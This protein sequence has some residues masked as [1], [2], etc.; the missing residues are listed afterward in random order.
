MLTEVA[1]T[2]GIPFL[3][4]P[5]T[6]LTCIVSDLTGNPALGIIGGANPIG[7]A[8]KA[9]ASGVAS[10][11]VTALASA[12][13]AAISAIVTD[14]AGLWIKLPSP[15]IAA[16]PI[17]HIIQAWLWPFTAAVALAGI[18]TS[19][20]RMTLTRKAAPLADVGAGLLTMAITTAAGT[21]LPT[22]LLQ[23]GDAYSNYVLSA[24]THGQFTKRFEEMFGAASVA[25]GSSV[26]AAGIVIG[27][28]LIF[29]IASAFQAVLLLF[30]MGSVIILSGTLSLAAAGRMTPVTRP[31]FPRVTGWLMALIFWK[32]A[33]ATVDATGFALFGQG[34]FPLDW[35]IGLAMIVLSLIAMPALVRLFTWTTGQIETSSGGGLLSAV[36]GG[37]AAVGAMRNAGGMSAVG[38]ASALSGML[39]GFGGG[40]NGAGTAGGQNGGTGPGGGGP[41]GGAGPGTV[42][43]ATPGGAGP[44]SG[45]SGGSQPGSSGGLSAASA[46]G[47]AG[48][49]AGGASMGAGAGASGAATAAGAAAGPAGVIVL[50]ATQVAG[51]VAGA[52]RQ[53]ADGATQPPEQRP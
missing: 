43:G 16:D 14:T 3:C 24:S 32:P 50:G 17:P 8:A 25:T 21:A 15:D 26:A 38:Q 48:P 51:A 33:A 11:A 22:L 39:G 2:A 27:L 46:A 35:L 13:Q 20:I 49:A 12:L 31:W 34:S 1:A 41:G 10:S 29:L 23:A 5:L 53:A 30:R 28:G 19:A 37:A 45:A 42:R 7:S 18:I 40:P 6:S 4:N 47:G 36:I 44:G 9:V 52:V